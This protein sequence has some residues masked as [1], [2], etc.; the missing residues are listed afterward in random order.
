MTGGCPRGERGG[1][2]GVRRLGG[3]RSAG[4]RSLVR[5]CFAGNGQCSRR[6]L[7]GGVH[8]GGPAASGTPP[9]WWTHSFRGWPSVVDP[10]PPGALAG[11]APP[12]LAP[13]A[14]A[15]ALGRGVPRV[16]AVAELHTG[17][18]ADWLPVPAVRHSAPVRHRRTPAGLQAGRRPPDDRRRRRRHRRAVDPA[19]TGRTVGARPP[20]L[21]VR[22]GSAA[23]SN[24]PGPRP[25]PRLRAPLRARAAWAARAGTGGGRGPAPVLRAGRRLG[26]RAA[27]TSHRV[28][29]RGPYAYGGPRSATT[30]S[31]RP[32]PSRRPRRPRHPGAR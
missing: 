8:G 15:P 29:T 20:R 9:R 32:T 26:P 3:R 10:R 4:T 16:P 11:A 19:T 18:A 25:G 17:P 6:R 13:R 27:G 21:R 2:H 14:L 24:P 7:K 30:L 22:T 28:V 5:G 1:P 23:Q 31:A 12:D